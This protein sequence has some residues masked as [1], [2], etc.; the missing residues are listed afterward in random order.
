M[1]VIYTEPEDLAYVLKIRWGNADLYAVAVDEMARHIAWG[2]KQSEA[3]RMDR[4]RAT[5]LRDRCNRH[6]RVIRLI[7]KS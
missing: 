6:V 4:A 1:T 5:S 2:E 7:P 3:V